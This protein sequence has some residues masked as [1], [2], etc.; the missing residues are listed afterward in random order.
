MLCFKVHVFTFGRLVLVCVWAERGGSGRGFGLGARGPV[1]VGARTLIVLSAAGF[2]KFSHSTYL[3]L[4]FSQYVALVEELHTQSPE[5]RPPTRCFSQSE[6][7][8]MGPL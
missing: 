2:L 1:H 8:L 5:K 4:P 6:L 3:F 7:F